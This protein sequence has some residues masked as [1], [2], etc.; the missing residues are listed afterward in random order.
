MRTKGRK[1]IRG[2]TA[3][4]ALANKPYA[5]HASSKH[6]HGHCYYSTSIH[7][8]GHR[9][10]RFRSLRYMCVVYRGISSHKST[11][12][13]GVERTL[14]LFLS[15][16]LLSAPPSLRLKTLRVGAFTP[17]L[18][19]RFETRNVDGSTAG[20]LGFSRDHV[21]GVFL[22]KF[23]LEPV[24]ESEFI[25]GPSRELHGEGDVLHVLQVPQR[26]DILPTERL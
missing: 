14:A 10:W 26:G 5:K 3:E 13:H 2:A 19:S 1:S 6:Q 22:S 23:E 24:V 12:A 16:L 18:F 25:R 11:G 15:R 8:S 17:E 20:G 9:I 4:K 7:L 21:W